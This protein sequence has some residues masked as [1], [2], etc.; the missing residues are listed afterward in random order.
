MKRERLTLI[1]IEYLLFLEALKKELA[2]NPGT[3]T[4]THSV[5]GVQ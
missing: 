5:R 2:K 1:P 4:L 3:T